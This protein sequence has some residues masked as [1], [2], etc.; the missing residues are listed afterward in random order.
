MGDVAGKTHRRSPWFQTYRRNNRLVGAFD[1]R[2]RDQFTRR[3][4]QAKPW[5]RTVRRL[6]WV[7][8]HDVGWLRAKS[9]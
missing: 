7:Q 5:T 1:R 4:D 9:R 2:I 3:E 6:D 8:G